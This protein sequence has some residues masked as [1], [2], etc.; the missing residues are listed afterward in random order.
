MIRLVQGGLGSG[1]V[2]CVDG[3][4]C[5]I[6]R[7]RDAVSGLRVYFGVLEDLGD[8]HRDVNRQGQIKPTV[9]GSCLSGATI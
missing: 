3:V 9:V 4:S 7:P 2:Q 5:E 1:A 8:M 6:L